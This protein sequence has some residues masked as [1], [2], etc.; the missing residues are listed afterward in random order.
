MNLDYAIALVQRY[1]EP[2]ECYVRKHR[3]RKFSSA[4]AVELPVAELK[5]KYQCVN[6]GCTANEAD[7]KKYLTK[8]NNVET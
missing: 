8:F 2:I 3:V 6:S 7:I 1:K 4:A 5:V